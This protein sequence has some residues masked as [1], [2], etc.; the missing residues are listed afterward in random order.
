MAIRQTTLGLSVT[1][2]RVLGGAFRSELQTDFYGGQQ[3]SSGG[4]TFPLLRIRTATGTIAWRRGELM[5]GQEQPLIAG[6]NPASLAGVGTPD[7]AGAGN[8]WLWLP[9]MR[10]TA[11]FGG[12]LRLAVQGAVLAPT[13]GDAAGAFD[14]DFDV[15]ERS[16][17]PF[18]QGR[19]RARWG[20]EET[21]GEIGA[22]V[23]HGWI[24]TTG[25][26]LLPS[27]A[28]SVDARIPIGGRVEVRGEGYSGKAL[29]GLG[30]GGIGQGLGAG[31]VPVRDAGGWAQ[32][33]VR[34]TTT[35]TLGAGCGVDDPEDKDLAAGARLKNQACAGQ[36]SWHPDGPLTVAVEYRRLE[37][38]YAARSFTNDHINLAVA[39]GF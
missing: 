10:A 5:V 26:S 30:G 25:D 1:A 4:R 20:S 31:G 23:H 34:P 33:L 35:W 36:L 21:A 37:T 14:T 19:V 29:K 39:F 2:D 17:R 6:L 7:F 32:L 8:L 9:Q 18:L 15:A 38:T 13:S 22:G 24:A 12:A 11:E 28:V 16:R 27:D 3:A